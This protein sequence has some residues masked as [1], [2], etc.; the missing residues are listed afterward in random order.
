MIANRS[1]RSLQATGRDYDQPS[2]ALPGL[3]EARRK[4][5]NIRSPHHTQL[6]ESKKQEK[7]HDTFILTNLDRPN[8]ELTS[9]GDRCEGGRGMG[10]ENAERNEHPASSQ[11]KRQKPYHH[12]D[13]RQ[14]EKEALAVPTFVSPKAQEEGKGTFSLVLF[15]L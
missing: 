10:I 14:K 5:T 2:R 8:S 13:Y 11:E 15:L 12:L 6:K 3:C 1:S 7:A 4:K 9:F